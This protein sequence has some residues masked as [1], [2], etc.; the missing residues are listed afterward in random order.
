MTKDKWFV[1]TRFGD[2]GHGLAQLVSPEEY[3]KRPFPADYYTEYDNYDE[4]IDVFDNQEDAQ[5]FYR[6]CLIECRAGKLR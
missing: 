5:D 6:E 4:Y 3:E 2:R 1:I